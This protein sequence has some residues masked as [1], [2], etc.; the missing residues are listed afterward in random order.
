MIDEEAHD[1]A[2]GTAGGA[3]V[4]RDMPRDPGVIEGEVASHGAAEDASPN[5]R[6]A[7]RTRR[8]A[9]P[10]QRRLSSRRLG[11][12]VRPVRPGARGFAAGALAGLIVSALAA[13]AGYYYL[14]Q[15]AGLADQAA[16]RLAGLETQAQRASDSLEAE[17]K[18]QNAAVASLDKRIAA[19]EGAAAASAA[20]GL[21]KRLDALD[22]ANAENAPKIA[23]ATQLAERLTT[24]VANLSAGVDGA[25]A[26]I[27]SLST[28]VSKLEAGTAPA[29][30]GP[31]VA[32]LGARID[33]VE[34]ALATQKS[35]TRVAPE[36]PSAE[37][38]PAAIAIIAAAIGDRLAAGAPFGPELADLKRLSVDPARLAALEAVVNGAPTDGA[39]AASFAA[40]APKVLAATSNGEQGGAV[41]RFLAHM[42]GLVQVRDLNETA[43]DDPQALVSQIEAETRRGDIGGALAAFGK[44]PEAARQAAGDWPAR[45]PPGRLRT[46]RCRQSAN[47]RSSALRAAQ[48]RE[49]A[50]T[51]RPRDS[52]RAPGV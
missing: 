5:A 33:K 50:G 46:P 37:D 38:N 1:V 47:W 18:R 34:A 52:R 7:T 14:T 9:R 3:P 40:A 24:Q 6:S 48:S 20:A 2:S 26:E 21:G 17:A 19:L 49:T 45:P 30:V 16:G 15:Q 36:K 22:A 39:L 35:E 4:N 31:D 8:R 41:D 51:G 43:G 11:A 44:L 28:R 29:S 42:R 25:R 32:A 12:P 23:A 27:A 10:T 13:G